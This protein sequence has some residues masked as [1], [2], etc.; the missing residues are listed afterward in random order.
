MLLSL[1]DPSARTERGSN[2]NGGRE[3]EEICCSA[4]ALWCSLLMSNGP[5]LTKTRIGRNGFATMIPFSSMLRW[6]SYKNY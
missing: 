4:V 3:K 5:G 2:K 6:V 1:E